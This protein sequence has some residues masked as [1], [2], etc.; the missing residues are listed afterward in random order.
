M[1]RRAAAFLIMAVLAISVAAY[2]VWRHIERDRELPEGV[3]RSNGRI[4][5]TR[6]DVAV[7]YPGRL[8]S[9][10]VQEGDVV[11]AGQVIAEQDD[12]EVLAQLAGAHASRERA[13][14]ALSRARGEEAAHASQADLARLNWAETRALRSQEMVSDT[15]LKQR[16]LA[17]TAARESVA[18]AAGGVGEARGAIG[19]A[20]AQ[21]Q[22]VTAI[23]DDLKIRAPGAGRIEYRIVEPG[24]MMAPGGRLVSIVNP[25]DVYLTIFVPASTASRISIGDEAR[26]VPQG[27]ISPLPARVSF[28]APDA[29]FTPKFV[30]TANE[31]DNLSYRV[32][33]RLPADIARRF[34]NQ[35]KAGMTADGYVRTDQTRAWPVISAEGR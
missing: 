25:E 15:E 1:K 3:V 35:L 4:E 18:A 29:Q 27:F 34:A 7:K 31:R 26:I 33:L 12:T 28:V 5:M 17:L 30:E 11:Q 13:L 22:Q 24:T 9:L 14:A 21:I 10:L 8:V 16:Q 19:Q 32:K 20:D 6:I 2:L 23:R